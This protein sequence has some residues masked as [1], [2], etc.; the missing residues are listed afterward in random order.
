MFASTRIVVS[1]AGALS[2]FWGA[3]A[4][5]QTPLGP[6]PV[7]PQ[8]PQTPEK[9]NVEHRSGHGYGAIAESI[10]SCRLSAVP[11]RRRNLVCGSLS[12]KGIGA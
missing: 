11:C 7:P 3:A 6:P 8:N 10:A 4:L 2:L 1:L 9:V 5:A 12:Q